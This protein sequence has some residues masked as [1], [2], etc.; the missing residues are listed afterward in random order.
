MGLYRAK[1][2]II[3][4][5]QWKDGSIEQLQEWA[6]SGVSSGTLKEMI[7]F[8]SIV[9]SQV[10]DRLVLVVRT[11]SGAWQSVFEGWW[12]IRESLNPDRFYPCPDED[13][14]NKYERIED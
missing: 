4:A 5:F 1:P 3:D 11:A 7:A 12:I 13:F 2:V 6:G 8:P 10:V 9:Y 14:R